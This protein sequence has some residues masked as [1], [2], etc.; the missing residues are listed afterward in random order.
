MPHHFPTGSTW[1]VFGMRKFL[2]NFDGD[3]SSSAARHDPE[4]GASKLAGEFNLARAAEIAPAIPVAALLRANSSGALLRARIRPASPSI[5]AKTR[6]RRAKA[7]APRTFEKHLQPGM[8]CRPR[9]RKLG[10][11]SSRE[12]A[13]RAR[14]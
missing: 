6:R 10:A 1:R 4:F 5:G 2:R 13:R 12:F 3:R 11:T 14:K 7:G 9:Q 8:A